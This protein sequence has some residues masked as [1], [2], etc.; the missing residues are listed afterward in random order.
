MKK[1]FAIVIISIFLF[2]ISYK[3]NST[4]K[5]S[6][7]IS[8]PGNIP[9]FS[10]YTTPQLMPGKA[11]IFNFTMKNRYDRKITD[12]ILT[13]EIYKYA[14]IH[15]SKDI[16]EI[17]NPP[18]IRKSGN[19]SVT[20]KFYE[21]SINE[22]VEVAFVIQTEKNTAQGTYFVRCKLSFLY[23]STEYNMKSRGYFSNEIWGKATES[24]DE[25]SP[26]NI[27]LTYL[28]CDGILPDS[29]FGVKNPIPIWPLYVLAFLTIFFAVL[30]I[31][32]YVE[33][34]QSSPWLNKRIQRLRGKFNQF[35]RFLKHWKK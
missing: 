32:F 22:T 34:T 19:Q 13:I 23:N 28:G 17:D 7:Y 14:T 9:E 8:Y 6:S 15:T 11:G 12:A 24:A 25:N 20:F 10:N 33:D 31:I 5:E 27:N 1:I 4:A 29:T 35:R 18:K 26:G 2:T 3:E 30:A 16:Q 21:I